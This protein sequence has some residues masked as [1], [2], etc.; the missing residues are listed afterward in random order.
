MTL[1]G[2]FCPNGYKNRHF[3]PA[4]IDGITLAVLDQTHYSSKM[5]L[6]EFRS[7]QAISVAVRVN[8]RSGNQKS[9]MRTRILLF[10]LF[11]LAA[12][13]AGAAPPTG[14]RGDANLPPAVGND[15]ASIDEDNVLAGTSVLANDSDPEGT[16]LAVT[17]ETKNTAHGKV[18]INTDG[19]YTYTP[20]ADYFGPDSFTYQVCD[21]DAAPE[22]TTGTVNLTV[23]PVQDPPVAT[24][25][26]FSTL[27]DT[28]LIVTC[29]CVLINDYD[30]DGDPLTGTLVQDVSHGTL[31]FQPDGTFVY[32][33]DQDFF[34]VDTFTYTATDGHSTTP[35]ALVT[36]NVIPVN[37]PPIAADDVVEAI[38]DVPSPLSL[39]DNDKDVDDVL[40]T[41][42]INVIS[43]PA[44]G[45]LQITPTQ[46][47]YTSHQDYNGPDTFQYILKD[48]AGA[49]SNTATVTIQVKPVND[50]PV[51][52]ADA[53]TTPE[54]TP[55]T[56]VVLA[57]D[58][59]VDNALDPA[60]V[61]ATQPAHGN[62]TVKADG[63]VIYSPALDYFGSD[64]FTYTVNDVEGATS[65]P[66]TV[67][68]TVTPVNDAPVAT[69]DNATTPQNTPVDV[70]LTDNDTDVDN[71]IV[72]GTVV[73]TV[74]PNH[75]SVSVTPEGVATYTPDTDYL[76]EDDFSYTVKDPSGL[77]SNPA[78]VTVTIIAQNQPPVAINDGPIKHPFL[79]NLSIDVLANDYD[80]DN[81]HA[82]LVIQSFTQPNAG[83]VSLE[84]NKLVYHP[85]GMTSTTITFTYTIADPGGLTCTATVTIEYEYNT[86]VV[87]EGFS[88]NNDNANDT[89]YIR[90][91]ENYP[92]N[93][94][95]VYDR[96]GL[97]V[98]Q[99]DNYENNVAPWDGRGNA[100]QMSGKLLD[101]GTYYYMLEIGGEVKV[102][103]GF[104]MITR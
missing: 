7:R 87:S 49:S 54:D 59:D 74:P 67:S 26:V 51:A 9:G 68:V 18:V 46:V 45:T 44:H 53:A 34:G 69:N 12:L 102:L 63:T 36:I 96:W 99:K 61:V 4:K 19:T 16:P 95:K 2:K 31:T 81:N 50:I 23:N 94:V 3:D 29:D 98:Y 78:V 57:N 70:D 33:P 52:A 79:T 86:L 91:I 104:V 84:G 56:I 28:K 27:E 97:L 21:S 10:L 72:P 41:S 55:V 58:T 22:C 88:P 76:G 11:T 62:V 48:A 65:L 20:N 15:V 42:M 100:G 80:V 17:P 1:D 66:A 64:N 77:T 40:T 60:A 24:D 73:I 82:D 30:P 43:P 8:G 47:L 83:S 90:S 75:G 71:P 39:L 13:Y 37:D 89:W 6:H 5:S 32:M 93:H 38:E 25:D 101:Q 103:S 35:P 92:S 14:I 85:A